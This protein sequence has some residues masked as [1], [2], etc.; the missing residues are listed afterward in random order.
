MQVR[1]ITRSLFAFTGALLFSLGLMPASADAAGAQL[2]SHRAIYDMQLYSAHRGS[3]L[4]GAR[5]SMVY[6]FRESCEGW[7]SE[8]N[9][10]M[11][12]IYAEGDQV[13]TDWAFAS[14]ESKD[15]KSYQY[16]TKQTR[17]GQEVENLK[18][19]VRR[20]APDAAAKA[21]FSSPEGEVIE[22][23]KETLFPT[24][25]LNELLAAGAAGKKIFSRMVFD[26]A[27]LDNPYRIN[28]IV[29]NKSPLTETAT[30]AKLE[31]V[32]KKAGLEN[33]PVKHY[34]MAFF[35]ARSRQ[36]APEFELGVDYRADGVSRFIRQDFGDFVIDLKLKDIEVFDRPG[37]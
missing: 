7:T 1:K 22:L 28:V 32:L 20:S 18:G 37:C 8:T 4:S 13:G 12:L 30:A 23:T 27:S 26:G 16:S 24:R 21:E 31:G 5:G 2:L 19:R 3:G 9:V 25:H 36:E 17:N 34:R 14:W 11:Q 6:S 10:K 15:G 33:L 35:P 29:V